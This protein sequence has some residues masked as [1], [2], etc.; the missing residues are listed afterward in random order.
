[1]VVDDGG[2]LKGGEVRPSKVLAGL[3]GWLCLFWLF[4]CGLARSA[5]QQPAAAWAVPRIHRQ[6]KHVT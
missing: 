5:V 6:N 4:G 2:G 1:M 3:L